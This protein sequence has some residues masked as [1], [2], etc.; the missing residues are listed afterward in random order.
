M[1]VLPQC[2]ESRPCQGGSLDGALSVAL[3][4]PPVALSLELGDELDLH[5]SPL[6]PAAVTLMTLF[7]PHAV[8]L[9]PSLP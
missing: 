2:S 3:A 4:L 9:L 6:T 1:Q 7:L 8:V 5:M